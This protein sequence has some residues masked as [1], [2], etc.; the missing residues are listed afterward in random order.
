MKTKPEMVLWD[1]GTTF[2]LENE[3]G[4]IETHF[5]EMAMSFQ[6]ILDATNSNSMVF[7]LRNLQSAQGGNLEKQCASET[8][9]CEGAGRAEVER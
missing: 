5:E 3:P 6:S 7:D 1:Y 2:E 9:P 4:L 8:T